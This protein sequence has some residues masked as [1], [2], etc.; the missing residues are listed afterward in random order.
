MSQA[1]HLEVVQ[2][3]NIRS[4]DGLV[5]IWVPGFLISPPYVQTSRDLQLGYFLNS[6]SSSHICWALLDGW[7]DGWMDGL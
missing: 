1:A 5:G 7:M 6:V 4:T 2:L 3:D